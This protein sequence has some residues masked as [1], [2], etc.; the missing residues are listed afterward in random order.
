MSSRRIWAL[1]IIGVLALLPAVAVALSIHRH[2]GF[3]PLGDQWHT[4]GALIEAQ[5]D[6]RL[7]WRQFFFQHNEARKAFTSAVW[8][9]LAV[10]G[11]HAR[12]EMYTT[13]LLVGACVLGY[14]QL[15]RRAAPHASLAP[16]LLMAI[17][18]V[19]LFNPIGLAGLQPPWFWGIGIENAVVILALLGGTCANVTLRSWPL[20]YTISAACSLAATY[21]FANGMLLWVLLH[22]R[23]LGP[24][25]G[26]G[27][28]TR[29]VL[30]LDAV[31][32][33]AFVTVVATYFWDYVRPPAHATLSD[34]LA[35]PGRIVEFFLAWL[36]APVSPRIGSMAYATAIGGAGLVLFV[37]SL[38]QV[39]RR[40]LWVRAL[41]FGLMATYTL[42]SAAAVSLG[43]ASMGGA[44]APRYFLHVLPF[45]LGLAGLVWLNSTAPRDRRTG[46]VAGLAAWTVIALPAAFVASNWAG[47]QREHTQVYHRLITRCEAA[48]CFAALVPDNPDLELQHLKVRDV[49]GYFTRLARVGIFD[50]ELAPRQAELVVSGEVLDHGAKLFISTEDERPRVHGEV[51]DGPGLELSHLLLRAR[52]GA[53]EKFVSVIPLAAYPRAGRAGARHVDTSIETDNFPSGLLELALLGYDE[54]TRRCVELGVTTEL[55]S[56]PMSAAEVRDAASLPLRAEAGV[57]TLDAVNGVSIVDQSALSIPRG[58]TIVVRGWAMDVTADALAARVYIKLGRRLF[59]AECRQPRLDVA[60]RLGRPELVASGFR[61]VLDAALLGAEDG[62]PLSVVIESRGG[63]LLEQPQRLMIQRGDG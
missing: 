16:A 34:S 43:R 8:M 41:P 24:W 62:G 31:Y 12:L 42:I 1:L 53:Q 11:W 28:P 15:C 63:E 32:L 35:S 47:I 58:E 52:S 17:A 5:L 39:V 45:Y 61:C 19:L 26:D 48:L 7:Y 25:K 56:G 6:G 13:V 37:W 36:G 9:A 29:R 40:G 18:S 50:V 60:Q 23:W 59:P 4:P 33:L 30:W 22:P 3:L 2:A 44:T 51:L 38:L 54:S 20:R 49:V 46:R 10:N 21:S 57:A 27:A 55:R 14:L